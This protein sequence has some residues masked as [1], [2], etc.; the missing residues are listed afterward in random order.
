MSASRTSSAGAPSSS[1]ARAARA[2]DDAEA[3]L[4]RGIDQQA[5][6]PGE[7]DALGPGRRP[8][9]A[10]GRRPR[11][12]RAPTGRA[13]CPRRALPA[14]RRRSAWRAPRRAPRRARSAMRVERLVLADQLGQHR[15]RQ[16][17]RLAAARDRARPGCGRGRAAPAARRWPQAARSAGAAPPS[18]LARRC[19]TPACRAPIRGSPAPT[20]DRG[21]AGRRPSTDRPKGR[22]AGGRARARP[23]RGWRPRPR[24]RRPAPPARRARAP[25]RTAADAAPGCSGARQAAPRTTAAPPAAARRAA[26]PRPGRRSRSGAG[27]IS[28]S[29]PLPH[30]RRKSI[31]SEPAPKRLTT[32][33]VAAATSLASWRSRH[34]SARLPVIAPSACTASCAPSRREKLPSMPTIVHRPT[35]GSHAARR[36][37]RSSA[38][39]VTDRSRAAGIRSPGSA[40]RR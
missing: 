29:S 5:P 24:P 11:P 12:H 28:T 21:T 26:R 40:P 6:P 38:Q 9:R 1:A 23:C 33:P 15:Q 32:G 27:S 37:A 30:G 35:P 18:R 36:A 20:R 2:S 7:R 3:A 17:A 39:A 34:P 13:A 4:R 14:C 19:G 31:S 22:P 10:P 16:H 8:S 25:R